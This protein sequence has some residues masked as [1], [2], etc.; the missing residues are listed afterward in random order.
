MKLNTFYLFGLLILSSIILGVLLDKIILTD[1]VLVNGFYN[2][3]SLSK[4]EELIDYKARLSWINYMVLPVFYFVKILL[5]GIWILSWTIFFG[6]KI[7]FREILRVVIKAEFVWLIPSLITLIWFHFI[8]TSY[9][10][11]DIQYF[12]PLSLLNF[13]SV[14]EVENWLIFPLQALSLFQVAY[15]I[16]L[17][18]GIKQVLSTNYNAALTFTIPVYGSALITWIVFITFLSMNLA[19]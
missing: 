6:H 9:T 14:S 7:S 10:L 11:V 2:Q 8:D 3:L 17:A 12:Q 5:I 15:I 4:I 16:F 19:A 13:F 18:I 1:E